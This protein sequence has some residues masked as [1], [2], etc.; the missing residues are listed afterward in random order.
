MPVICDDC[1][2]EVSLD[3]VTE[4]DK[5]VFCGDCKWPV[6][7]TVYVHDEYAASEIEDELYGSKHDPKKPRVGYE[8]E[9][10]ALYYED[11]SY[12]ITEVNSKK[13]ISDDN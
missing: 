9:L 5:G 6:E 10:T 4:K 2:D 12:E 11:G 3:N 8:V 1:G 7:R 13:V